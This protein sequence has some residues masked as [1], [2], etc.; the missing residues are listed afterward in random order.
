LYLV[1]LLDI[2]VCKKGK[3]FFLVGDFTWV[4]DMSPANLTFDAMNEIK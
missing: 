3:D 1:I 2:V 4:R